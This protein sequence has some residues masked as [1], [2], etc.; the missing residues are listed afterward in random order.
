VFWQNVSVGAVL[1]VRMPRAAMRDAI[2]PAIA[3]HAKKVG[4]LFFDARV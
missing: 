4:R 3:D 2:P 1:V